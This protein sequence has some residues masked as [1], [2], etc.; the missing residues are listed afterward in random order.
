VG[1]RSLEDNST[2]GEE[3]G[4]QNPVGSEIKKNRHRCAPK[5]APRPRQ[6]KKIKNKR[7]KGD[8][9][10]GDVTALKRKKKKKETRRPF[11]FLSKGR[12]FEPVPPL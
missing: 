11:E 2:E 12:N 5:T 8:E 6:K 1:T 3:I 4:K 9:V 7:G 10:H